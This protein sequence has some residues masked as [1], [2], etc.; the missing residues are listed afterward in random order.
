MHHSDLFRVWESSPL[1]TTY[2][3]LP[4]VEPVIFQMLYNHV[5]L[6]MRENKGEIDS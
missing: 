2:V 1:R 3:E 5:C 4:D 6:K